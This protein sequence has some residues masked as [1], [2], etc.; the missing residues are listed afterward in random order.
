MVKRFSKHNDA[1]WILTNIYAPCTYTGKREFLEWF[2]DIQMPESVNWLVVGELNLCRS[3]EDRNRPGGDLSEML[4]FNED[5]SSL[6]LIEVPLKG[7]R[8]T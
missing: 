6:G 5:I 2:S 8:Y 3:P 7:R 1:H 4:L